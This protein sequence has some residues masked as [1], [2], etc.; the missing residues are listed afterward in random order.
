MAAIQHDRQAYHDAV[1]GWLANHGLLLCW[2]FVQAIP[3]SFVVW[4]QWVIHDG[5]IKGQGH[6]GLNVR[7]QLISMPFSSANMH[8]IKR[9]MVNYDTPR[10]YPNF[11]WTD[12]WHLSSFCVTRP[13][14]LECSTFG[15][16]ILLLTRSHPA[17]PY[18][19]YYLLVVFTL[20]VCDTYS[21]IN[22]SVKLWH[23]NDRKL[24]VKCNYW[25]LWS[26]WEILFENLS[27]LFVNINQN[28]AEYQ[29]SLL[30]WQEEMTVAAVMTV[31][32]LIVVDKK[33]CLSCWITC[34]L[35]MK[36]STSLLRVDSSSYRLY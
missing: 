30:F 16:W 20:I 24:E 3:Q 8:V 34:L 7:K 32:C 11:N 19:A 13:S 27:A 35:A 15:K 2:F 21:S 33:R 10:Q 18:A 5:M 6:W 29:W 28:F 26:F 22:F 31:M 4:G 12:F 9:L 25:Q 1:I 14:N 17:V 23:Y 36:L